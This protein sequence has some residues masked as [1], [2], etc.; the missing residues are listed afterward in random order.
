MKTVNLEIVL[1]DEEEKLLDHYLKE[2]RK[3]EK[4]RNKNR[5]KQVYT[6]QKMTME[7]LLIRIL[8]STLVAMVS[9]RSVDFI[10]GVLRCFYDV[11]D[12]I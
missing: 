1:S 5:I 8:Y 9:Q 7:S 4:A 12:T 10:K 11:E 2:K 3:E 6:Y